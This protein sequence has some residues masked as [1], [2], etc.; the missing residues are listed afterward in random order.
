MAI[1]AR[2]T[3]GRCLANGFA[4]LRSDD[5]GGRERSRHRGLGHIGQMGD[6]NRCHPFAMLAVWSLDL[7]SM[8][9][10]SDDVKGNQDP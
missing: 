7:I 4:L 9:T 10:Y 5:I 2:R 1:G 8:N 3:W 6:V